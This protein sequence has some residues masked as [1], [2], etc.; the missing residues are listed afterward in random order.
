MFVYGETGRGKGEGAGR[1]YSGTWTAALRPYTF[2]TSFLPSRQ[3]HVVSQRLPRPVCSLSID[4]SRA[5][6]AGAGGAIARR[7]AHCAPSP[8]GV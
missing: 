6:G 4:V 8:R 2:L 7:M 1:G 3:L 5:Q